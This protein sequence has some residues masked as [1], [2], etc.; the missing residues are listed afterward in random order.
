VKKLLMLGAVVGG[1]ALGVRMLT[2]AWPHPRSLREDFGGEVQR[3]KD[4]LAEAVA[5]GKRAMAAREEEFER[6]LAAAGR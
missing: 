4:A 1:A 3:L 5:A 6:E 2:G